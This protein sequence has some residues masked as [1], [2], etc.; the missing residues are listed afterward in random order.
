M[1]EATG[2]SRSRIRWGMKRSRST[3]LVSMTTWFARLPLSKVVLFKEHRNM[4]LLRNVMSI[5]A[6]RA[7]ER[8][9]Q[10]MRRFGRE[11][12]PRGTEG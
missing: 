9:H 2:L 3:S 8:S 1:A 4:V 7:L 10:D 12:G 11:R 6:S 5:C